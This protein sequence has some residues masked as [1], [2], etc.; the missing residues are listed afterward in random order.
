MTLTPTT[1]MTT[2]Q[3]SP[4]I[5]THVYALS[6][7]ARSELLLLLQGHQSSQ[8]HLMNQCL[9]SVPSTTLE[10]KNARLK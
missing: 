2:V 5:W 3:A 6:A 1:L 8:P 10:K 9:A 4:E 7:P